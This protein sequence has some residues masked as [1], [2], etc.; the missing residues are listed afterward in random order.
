[1]YD[2]INY[3]Q[4]LLII[5]PLVFFAG[6]INAIGGGGGLISLPA[7]YVAGLPPRMAQATNKFA[8]SFGTAIAA[9]RFIKSGK[10]D[11]FAAAFGTVA[12][13]AGSALGAYLT[14]VVDEN[15]LRVMLVA[16]LPF[17]AVFV[18]AS[19]N[20]GQDTPRKDLS[21]RKAAAL[22]VLIGFCLGAYD[23]FFGPGT[24]TFLIILFNY[25]NFRTSKILKKP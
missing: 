7:L 13:L 19:K 14:H 1:M 17:V 18:L 6:F 25:L 12:A 9:A 23:G 3:G 2:T 10:V 21:K 8:M 11:F 24:G 20:M 4:Q 15:I 22:C 16:V 5:L